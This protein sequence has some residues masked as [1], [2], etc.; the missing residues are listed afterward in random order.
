MSK[1]TL[2][3]Q[4]FENLVLIVVYILTAQIG[5]IFAIPPG[6]VTAI[7]LPSGIVLAAVCIRGLYLLPAIFIGAFVGNAWS[8]F[9]M[10][11]FDLIVKSVFSGSANGFGDVLCVYI[12][13]WG[14]KKALKK[15]ALY[16]NLNEFL[17]FLF[18]AVFVGSGVSAFFGVTSLALSGFIDWNNYSSSLLTWWTG[19]SV[20]ILLLTPLFFVFYTKRRRKL[21]WNLE[22]F[23]FIFSL[24]I[25]CFV[26][27]DYFELQK[28][29]NISLFMITPILIWGALRL[30]KRIG[31]IGVLLVAFFAIIA[32]VFQFGHFSEKS[33]NS[34]LI[35]LQLFMTSIA[36]TIYIVYILTDQSKQA[37]ELQIAK[38]RAEESEE[39]LNRTGEIARVGGWYLNEKFDKVFWT[40]TTGRIHELPDG[41]V[42]TLEEAINYYHPDDRDKV[43]E[44]VAAAISEGVPYNFVSRMITAKGNQ[45]WVRI[46]GQPQMENG[47]CVRLSGTFQDISEQ[48]RAEEELL[49]AKEK[50]EESDRLK[51]AFLSNMSHE[52]RT[53][54]NGILGFTELLKEPD[55]TENEKVKFINIIRKSGN[56]LL[57]TVNDIIDVSKIDS[58]QME[59]SKTQVHI[60]EEVIYQYEFFKHEAVNKGIELNLHFDNCDNDTNII[61]DKVKLNSI[62]SN[63]IKNA[64]KYTDKGSIDIFCSRRDAYHTIKIK[65]TGIGIPANKLNSV[66]DRF[67]QVDSNDIHARQGSGLGLSISK[68]YVEALGGSISVESESGIGS[69]FTFT[70]PIRENHFE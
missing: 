37:K 12:G 33:V 4:L 3:E 28:E 25:G 14:V 35:E 18:F 8:Y 22:V 13:Y 7:W 44:S 45:I 36:I 29:I 64:I 63:L 17:G 31:H 68:A 30:D 16:R 57:D 40:Q 66:F 2:F 39:F 46:I 60:K 11:S 41:F 27:V 58:G 54:L 38:K 65:D 20:G 26:L 69:S 67:T 62:I 56:S 15:G 55:L 48:K 53:P 49:I 19:D 50:A 23:A 24:I 10:S 1:K 59:M 34:A 47:K 51:S 9:D 21:K 42:P 52:I 32:T 61:T 5:Q 6:N 70:L 43:K